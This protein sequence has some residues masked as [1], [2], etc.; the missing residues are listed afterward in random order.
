MKK[1]RVTVNGVAY[2][3]EVEILE[4]EEETG[5][6]YDATQMRPPPVAPVAAA[7]SAP[8]IAP[9]RPPAAPSAGGDSKNLTSPV[10]GVVRGIKVKVGDAVKELTP[11]IIIET[12]KMETIISSPVE[13]KIKSI[14][15]EASQDV[16][17]GQVLVTFE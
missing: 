9:P 12:M 13:G 3:V 16:K 6:G 2:D 7:P 14:E 5:Y 4:D 10:P 15:V 11:L 8:P 17:Q 1:L